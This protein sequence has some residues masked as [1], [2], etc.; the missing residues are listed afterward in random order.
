MNN[1]RFLKTAATVVVFSALAAIPAFAG[2]WKQEADGRW[3][4]INDDGTPASGWQWIDSDNDSIAECYYFYTDDHHMANN[5]EQDGCYLNIDGKWTDQTTGVV[6]TK[7]VEPVQAAPAAENNAATTDN[8]T[9]A[10]DAVAGTTGISTI[11]IG[12]GVTIE[13]GSFTG[14][15]CT[16]TVT[17]AQLETGK[18]YNKVMV[19]LNI[20]KINHVNS[21]GR[22]KNVHVLF[23]LYDSNGF[24]IGHI[25]KSFAPETAAV[26]FSTTIDKK[27]AKIGYRFNL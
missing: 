24:E 22:N 15:E 27:T 6:K 20:T 16:Y 17:A 12:N 11:S 9:T 19:K 10:N 3:Y 13:T 2:Q 18:L 25:N 26:T 23:T 5:E 8:K 21:A 4:Y 1:K 7:P 14:T